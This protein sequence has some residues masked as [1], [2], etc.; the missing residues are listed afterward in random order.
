MKR[1]SESNFGLHFD[2]HAD[3]K[4]PELGKNFRAED[5]A[6]LMEEVRPDFVQCDTKGHPGYASY[7]SELGNTAPG[8][9][10]DLLAE[11]RKI[12]SKYDV[13]L[14]SHYSGIWDQK[15]S[16]E[17][18]EW[19]QYD[20]NGVWTN[21]NSVFSEYADKVLIPQLKEL[22]ARGINGVWV[23]AECWAMKPD[24]SEVALKA[25]KEATGLTPEKEGESFEA[26]KNFCRKGFFAYVKKYVDAV[27]A[28]YPE[29]E[30][31]S[32]WMYTSF[33]P[34][35]P[36]ID[37]D[38]ISGD[39]DAADSLNTA[40]FEA[41]CLP[42]QGKP[43][44]LMAWAFNIQN[45][46]YVN[47]STVQLLQEIAVPLSL[48]G[49]VQVYNFEKGGNIQRWIVPILKELAQFARAHSFLHKAEVIPQIGILFSNKGF[50]HNKKWIFSKYDDPY[51][52]ETTGLTLAFTDAGYGVDVLFTHNALRCMD[53]YPV[54]VLP[55]W[56]VIEA[57]LKDRL[58]AY[59]KRGGKLIVIGANALD[60]VADTFALKKGEVFDG[61]TFLEENGFVTGIITSGAE[62]TGDGVMGARYT[63]SYK[64]SNAKPWCITKRY[65]KG[66]VF[67]VPFAFG[68]QYRQN[69]SFVLTDIVREIL[70]KAFSAPL[71]YLYRRRRAD[72]TLL[73]KDGHT[74]LTLLNRS[75]D[76]ENARVRSFDDLTPLSDIKIAV[77]PEVCAARVME[78]GET[79]P[80]REENGERI[81]VLPLLNVFATIELQ[82]R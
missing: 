34:E 54:L 37:V 58:D 73:R 33:C 7:F 53:E 51:V 43:W 35:Q 18:P 30:I 1:R 11:W 27:H 59:V 13:A 63:D 10:V 44:D 28:E 57:E 76:H 69:Y 52:A 80:I 31:A 5:V 24:F 72:M 49:G 45:A 77:A 41:R 66:E 48:G 55:D 56:Q 21:E 62:C 22:A 81:I 60:N 74:Y 38:F 61:Q 79:L 67:V 26:Y 16:T 71:A 78:T 42:R 9:A 17:H 12:T 23:D 14:L 68:L 29:F 82:L 2:F 4:T 19:R 20:E 47:K 32:N 75:G 6:Y 70:S 39:Y 50:Y 65:G 46:I 15:A 64:E 36:T 40:R 25:Y 8:L 3:G